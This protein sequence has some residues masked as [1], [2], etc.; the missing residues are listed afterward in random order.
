MDPVQLLTAFDEA[1][2]LTSDMIVSGSSLSLPLTAGLLEQMLLNLTN[3]NFTSANGSQ[4]YV[5]IVATNANGRRSPISNLGQFIFD[6]IST[7]TTTTPPL[8][9]PSLTPTPSQVGR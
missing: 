4:I 7:P 1:F 5:A 8:S 9:A 6:Q 2:Q 3:T